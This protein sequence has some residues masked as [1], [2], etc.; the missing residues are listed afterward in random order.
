MTSGVDESNEFVSVDGSRMDVLRQIPED[1]AMSAFLEGYYRDV[2]ENSSLLG[3]DSQPL[4]EWDMIHQE[5]EYVGSTACA[6]CHPNQNEH[7]SQTDH[8]NAYGTLLDVHRHQFPKC[9]KCHVAG[10]GRPPD[11]T[12][13]S[14]EESWRTCSA[15]SATDLG[16]SMSRSQRLPQSERPLRKKPASRVTTA[17]MTTTFPMNGISSS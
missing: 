13:W 4:F 3:W 5:R 16:A 1:P 7:W 2:A 17:T 10:L 12:S 9:V 14:R 6:S 15:K 11:S 8:A